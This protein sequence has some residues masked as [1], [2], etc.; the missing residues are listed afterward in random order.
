MSKI[1]I[2]GLCPVTVTPAD[3]TYLLKE[4]VRGYGT[5]GPCQSHA[6]RGV[7]AYGSEIHWCRENEPARTF[8]FTDEA[9]FLHLLE[10]RTVEYQ[11]P[12]GD[13]T[14]LVLM[15]IQECFLPHYERFPT[16]LDKPNPEEDYFEADAS[17]RPHSP[18]RSMKSRGAQNY[19][20]TKWKGYW[21][22]VRNPT[23]KPH[24]LHSCV[25]DLAAPSILCGGRPTS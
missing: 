8:D 20:V 3:T 2:G 7:Q 4:K 18:P 21:M 15:P 17:W 23:K 16:I 10:R 9:A 14:P 1:P 13:A 5:P 22:T 25:P 12:I 6:P 24:L 19:K 11:Q